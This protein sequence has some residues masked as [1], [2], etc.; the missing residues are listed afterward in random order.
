VSSW[1]QFE[2]AQPSSAAHI[3]TVFTVRDPEGR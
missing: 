3:H 1:I 2:M